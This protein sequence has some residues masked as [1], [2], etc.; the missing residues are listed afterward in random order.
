MKLINRVVLYYREGSSDKVYEVDLCR[1][2]QS[3]YVVNFR[4]GRRGSTLKEGTKTV[5]AVAKAEAERVFND[6]VDSKVKKGY[7]TELSTKSTPA[8]SE[9]AVPIAG[10]PTVADPRHQV[11][12]NRLANIN[13]ASRSIIDIVFRR[14]SQK[15]KWPLER[16]I[17]RAGQLK[18]KEAAPFLINL[19]NTGTELRDYSIAWALGWCG[20][21]KAIP[22]LARLYRDVSTT[23]S[24]RRIAGEALLR[25]SDKE[26]KREFQADMIEKLPTSLQLLARNGSAEDFT[27]ALQDYLDKKKHP[28]D[29]AVLETI[30]QID[31]QHVRPALLEVLRTAPLRPNYFQR[32]RHIFK[33]AEYRRDGEVFG[34]IAYRFEKEKQ[35]FSDAYWDRRYIHIL[36]NEGHYETIEKSSIKSPMSKIAYGERTRNYLR[37]RV[38]RTLNS[39]GQEKDTDYV[40]LA[41]GVLLPF[42]D[43]DSGQSQTPGSRQVSYRHTFGSY[44][45]FS[46]IL[47][48]NSPHHK[49]IAM[50][51]D[52]KKSSQQTKI[53]E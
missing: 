35:M 51:W 48:R 25:L 40:R 39:L 30:Y 16:V 21:E 36:S 47:Y 42:T 8:K 50:K 4:Y 7:K 28:S 24:V 34:L 6:L 13:T 18:I 22:V 52:S 43:E 41:V 38:W 2:D 31:N 19:I 44:W 11:V 45:A 53:R 14:G 3:R 37:R 20:D 9:A 46:N 10:V 15:E 26:T 27:V 5:G 23:D 49:H 33:A 17:W 12:L 32:I 1:L 29:L